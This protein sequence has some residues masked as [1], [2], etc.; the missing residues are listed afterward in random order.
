MIQQWT[1]TPETGMQRKHFQKLSQMSRAEALLLLEP[2][3]LLKSATSA[4]QFRCF[5]NSNIQLIQYQQQQN[6]A[7]VRS[8]DTI[9]LLFFP[10]KRLF[11]RIWA[12][13]Q[14]AF[15]LWV[16]ELLRLDKSS[17]SIKYITAAFIT[18][19]YPQAIPTHFWTFPETL[20]PPLPYVV[21]YIITV[22]PK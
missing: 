18:K 19:L 5:L 14:S 4:L 17:K 22:V 15:L 7:C 16:T 2:K 6:A 10:P 12:F 20:A 11:N 21:Q 1:L 8:K 3:S 13:L 9:S